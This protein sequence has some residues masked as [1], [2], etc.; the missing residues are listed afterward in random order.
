MWC[1]LPRSPSPPP[2]LQ[3]LPLFTSLWLVLLVEAFQVRSSWEAL[4]AMDLLLEPRRL[5]SAWCHDEPS[6]AQGLVCRWCCGATAAQG[7]A[8]QPLSKG[9]LGLRVASDMGALCGLCACAL[10]GLTFA[11]TNAT[12]AAYCKQIAGPQL[13]STTQ[14]GRRC[15]VPRGC[16]APTYRRWLG[17]CG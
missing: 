9:L 17:L 15:W 1:A 7:R 12:A 11:G 6:L 4:H 8:L 16:E 3:L 2:P 5:C 14:A 13:R 10:Q